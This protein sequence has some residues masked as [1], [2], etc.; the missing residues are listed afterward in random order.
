MEKESLAVQHALHNFL[1]KHIDGSD[2]SVQK[3]EKLLTYDNF[4]GLIRQN[5]D[6]LD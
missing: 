2:A 4:K 6:F 1:A 5:E 3:L